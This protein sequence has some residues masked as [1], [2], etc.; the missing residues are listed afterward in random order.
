MS[1]KKGLPP[2]MDH[3]PDGLCCVQMEDMSETIYK[4]CFIFC[5]VFLFMLLYFISTLIIAQIDNC[6]TAV[7]ENQCPKTVYSMLF[8]PFGNYPFHFSCKP[9]QN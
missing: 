2:Q 4:I 7:V 9:L 5:S 3:R 6:M 1:D 8:G